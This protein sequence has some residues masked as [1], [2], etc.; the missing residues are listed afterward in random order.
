MGELGTTDAPGL[1]A[2]SMSARSWSL[3]LPAALAPMAS[4]TVTTVASRFPRM[5]PGLIVPL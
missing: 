1:A 4:K 3:I 2:A 5:T